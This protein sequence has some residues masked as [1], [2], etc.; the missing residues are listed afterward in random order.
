M[1]YHL[2]GTGLGLAVSKEPF[3]DFGKVRFTFQG[4]DADYVC[5]C[6]S[7]YPI[8][9]G[10]AEVSTEGLP[11][12]VSVS[13]Y[14]LENRRHYTCDPLVRI[15]SNGSEGTAFLAPTPDGERELITL[16]SDRLFTIEERLLAAE[17]RLAAHNERI[18]GNPITFG[19]THET[20]Q[21]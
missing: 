5:V 3:P 19:G 1:I 16:L 13:A 7:F 15:T 11:D 4:E 10:T 17:Q 9:G 12:T 14:S 21:S 20:N 2:S 6:G 8:V 18:L